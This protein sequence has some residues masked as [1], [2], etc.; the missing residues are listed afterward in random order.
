MANRFR[1]LIVAMYFP[2]DIGGSATRVQNVAKGLH[3]NGCEVTVIAAVPHYPLGDVPRQYRWRPLKVEW[4]DGV[5]VIRTFMFPLESK[6]FVSRLLHI[7]VFIISS[8]FAFP[9]IGRIDSVWA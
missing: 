3:L 1:V 4:V 2:P 7:G 5:R 8:M 9:F 6:G